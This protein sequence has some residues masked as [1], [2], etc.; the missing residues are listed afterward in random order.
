MT[1][2]LQDI[3]LQQK[4]AT[5]DSMTVLI[6]FLDPFEGATG[7]DCFCTDFTTGDCVDSSENTCTP[8]AVAE[9]VTPETISGLD[10]LEQGIG[11]YCLTSSCKIDIDGDGISDCLDINGSQCVPTDSDDDNFADTCLTDANQI[12]QH[13][14]R[15]LQSQ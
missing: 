2:M 12:R 1:M 11:C 8:D 9:L 3:R 5:V 10:Y 14:G 6:H 15:F 7:E 4:S 13:F